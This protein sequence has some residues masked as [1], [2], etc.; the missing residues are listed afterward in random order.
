MAALTFEEIRNS[1]PF[2]IVFLSRFVFLQFFHF[3]GVGKESTYLKRNL[4]EHSLL[5]YRKGH[6]ERLSILHFARVK[7]IIFLRVSKVIGG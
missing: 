3:S 4:N 7:R 2:L 6:L 1:P 5:K